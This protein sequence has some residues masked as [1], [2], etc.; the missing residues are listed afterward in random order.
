MTFEIKTNTK[1]EQILTV[2]YFITWCAFIG[3]LI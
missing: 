3:I 1:T 2:M